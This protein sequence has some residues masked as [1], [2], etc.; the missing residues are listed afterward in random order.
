V[1]TSIKLVKATRRFLD[2]RFEETSNLLSPVP[3]RIEK[4]ASRMFVMDGHRKKTR[5]PT[6][7]LFV[8]EDLPI[9]RFTRRPRE[10]PLPYVRCSAKINAETVN[11]FA[12]G[13]AFEGC[14]WPA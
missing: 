11:T 2:G 6:L 12:G 3:H 1:P 8:N 14:D 7:T 9:D 10:L 13:Q 5:F 4:S